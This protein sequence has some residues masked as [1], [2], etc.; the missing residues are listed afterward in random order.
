VVLASLYSLLLGKMHSSPIFLVQ[1]GL[2]NQLIQA[3]MLSFVANSD[4]TNIR[5]NDHLLNSRIR[6]IRKVTRR[7]LSPLLQP[8]Y[9]CIPQ[10]LLLTARLAARLNLFGKKLYS[11]S[12]NNISL[13]NQRIFTGDGIHPFAFSEATNMYWT[14]VVERLDALCSMNPVHLPDYVAIHVRK[15]DYTKRSVQ[16]NTGLYP[17]PDSYYKRA[18]DLLAR[19]SPISFHRVKIFTDSPNECSALASSLCLPSEIVC[20]SSPEQ[21]LFQISHAKLLILSNSTFSILGAHLASIR[22]KTSISVAP[23]EWFSTPRYNGTRY[24]LRG[25]ACYTI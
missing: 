9:V 25:V 1:G 16:L 21:D 17:L 18:L 10:R 24:D 7:T 5:I 19:V 23:H 6:I 11:D 4:L 22:D 13:A 20:S 2:G 8:N 15:G 14:N 3:A 12:I